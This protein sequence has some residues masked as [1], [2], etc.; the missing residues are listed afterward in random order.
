MNELA[1]WSS[2]SHYRWKIADVLNRRRCMPLCAFVG[3]YIRWRLHCMQKPW[4]I[5]ESLG[6]GANGSTDQR[7]V[8]QCRRRKWRIVFYPSPPAPKFI[9]LISSQL[10]EMF[11]HIGLQFPWLIAWC[12]FVIMTSPGV[13]RIND[14]Q[15]REQLSLT[16]ILHR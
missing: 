4:R 3:A 14:V 5:G 6:W 15:R 13:R 2:E 1:R 7:N 10:H 9:Y 12:L 11:E 8:A 16:T